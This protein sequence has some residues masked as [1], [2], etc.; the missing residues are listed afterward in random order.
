MA[1][2]ARQKCCRPKF[3]SDLRATHDQSTTILSPSVVVSSTVCQIARPS[4]TVRTTCSATFE[5]LVLDL[6]R[7]YQDKG[8]RLLKYYQS[9]QNGHLCL[10]LPGSDIS[11]VI[12]LAS[13]PSLCKEIFD[14]STNPQTSLYPRSSISLVCTKR[15]IAD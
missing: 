5:E 11:A 12:A 13:I 6:L 15:A 2:G 10:Y 1:C 7:L 9:V 8:R 14:T 4:F 3:T